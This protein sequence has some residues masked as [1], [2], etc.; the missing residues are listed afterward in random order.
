MSHAV[1]QDCRPFRNPGQLPEP[2]RPVKAFHPRKRQGIIR[3]VEW[4][5]HAES[6]R[7]G[8]SQKL[9]IFRKRPVSP[10]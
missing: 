3:I 1:I 4:F 7:S 8:K 5:H 10:I 6:P 2:P 9:L